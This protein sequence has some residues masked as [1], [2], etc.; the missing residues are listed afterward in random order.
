MSKNR[1]SKIKGIYPN[2]S[3]RFEVTPPKEPAKSKPV[4]SFIHMKHGTPTC[5]SHKKNKSIKKDIVDTLLLLS[6]STWDDI[7]S[8]NIAG[9]HIIP[10]KQ[11]NKELPPFITPDIKKLE[12]F[13]PTSAGRMAGLRRGDIFH[14]VQIR[15][16]HDMY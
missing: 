7:I 14:I 2:S 13:K 9:Y 4:F 12:V 3:D 16:E 6:K 10:V 8:N 5:L 1:H 11:F 15:A